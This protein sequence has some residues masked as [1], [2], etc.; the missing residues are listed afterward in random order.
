[1]NEKIRVKCPKCN[2]AIKALP[3][4]LDAINKCPRCK[5]CVKLIEVD[6]ENSILQS[7]TCE[8]EQEVYSPKMIIWNSVLVKLFRLLTFLPI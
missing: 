7:A 4:D 1:M 2:A 8:A 6:Q 5:E 3:K